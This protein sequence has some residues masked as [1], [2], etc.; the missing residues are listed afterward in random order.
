MAETN[1]CAMIVARRWESVGRGVKGKMRLRIEMV[2]QLA[3]RVE[4]T[5]SEGH[6]LIPGGGAAKY[7]GEVWLESGP[8][9][10]E[11]LLRA[12]ESGEWQGIL[13]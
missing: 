5:T 12:G 10:V 11:N 7:D 9:V 1:C 3:A 2:G 8:R 6:S 4:F 13:R